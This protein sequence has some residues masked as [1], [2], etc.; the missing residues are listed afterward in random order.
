MSTPEAEHHVAGNEPPG[1][2]DIV[3]RCRG[4]SH[5]FGSHPI[6]HDVDLDVVRG[7]VVSV[8][9]PSGCGKSTLLRAVIGTHPPKRGQILVN[10][11][12]VQGPGRDRGIVYQHYSL[13]PFLSALDNVAIG[14]R[15]DQTTL[16]ERVLHPLRWRRKA[17]DFREQA[18]AMLERLGLGHAKDRFPHQLSGGMKQRVAM[19]QALIMKPDV[20]LLDEPFGALDEAMRENLQDL[21]VDL[22][23]KN[24]QARA[25]GEAPPYTIMIVTHELNEALYVSNRVIGL[26]QSWRYEDDGFERVPG[27]TVVYDAAAPISRP[28]QPRDYVQWLDQKNEIREVVFEPEQRHPRTEYRRFWRELREEREGLQAAPPTD[29]GAPS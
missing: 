5:W 19:G 14:L 15:L 1:D 2:A 24:E 26:S 7:H 10:G 21:L 29:D 23:H 6:L 28:D 4:V 8:V 22:F 20:L 3:L 9:G 13:F 27:A 25:R 12:Q 11:Q 18:A 17:A 16:L